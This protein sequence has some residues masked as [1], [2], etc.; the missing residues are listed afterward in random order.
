MADR[1][2]VEVVFA[3][4][5]KQV[6]L[7]VS[8]PEGASVADALSESGLTGRFPEIDFA[9]LQSGVWGHPVPRNHVL[10]NG[11]RVEIYRPMLL[12]PKEARRQ[13]ASLGLTMGKVSSD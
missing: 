9:H 11:D 8:L 1:V 7:S 12:D 6:L 3:K 5:E 4:P 10:S 13:L 2:Q